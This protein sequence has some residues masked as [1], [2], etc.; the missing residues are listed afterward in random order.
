MTSAD[1]ATSRHEDQRACGS[2]S[3][4]GRFNLNRSPV[5][6]HLCRD[7]K[8]GVDWFLAAL[9][10]QNH[11][12]PNHSKV[13]QTEWQ[14]AGG[15]CRRDLMDPII[16]ANEVSEATTS[17]YVDYYHEDRKH[18]LEC[19]KGTPH[20]RDS[21]QRWDA[22]LSASDLAG[23]HHRYDRRLTRGLLKKHQ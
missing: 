1:T 5:L 12:G 4:P 7:G 15:E 8:Y 21:S 17:E 6:F 11:S 9:D 18:L 14:S 2:F 10:H 13:W 23:L 19:G 22:W 3:N 20:S 16:A